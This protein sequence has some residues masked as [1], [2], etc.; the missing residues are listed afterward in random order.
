M[1]HCDCMI[2]FDRKNTNFKPLFLNRKIKISANF[3]CVIIG[4]FDI[5]KVS[6]TIQSNCKL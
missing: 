6:I 3:L 5:N 2:S 1:Q 4:P